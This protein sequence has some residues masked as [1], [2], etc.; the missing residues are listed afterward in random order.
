MVLTGLQILQILITANGLMINGQKLLVTL[1]GKEL[2]GDELKDKIAQAI[3]EV[4][5]NRDNDREP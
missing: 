5:F 2:T 3:I 1:G 4:E